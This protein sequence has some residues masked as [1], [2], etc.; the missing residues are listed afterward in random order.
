[1]G[2]SAAA[3]PTAYLPQ[4]ALAK[5]RETSRNNVSMKHHLKSGEELFQ[6]P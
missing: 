1:M 5:V 4:V 2:P 6:K 3:V